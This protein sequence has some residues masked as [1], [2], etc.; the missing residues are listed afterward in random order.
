VAR[1]ETASW[2]QAEV[3]E[4]V[5]WGNLTRDE[6][7]PGSDLESMWRQDPQSHS[8]GPA[9]LAGPPEW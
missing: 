5:R 3:G 1:R 2:A 8:G 6:E 4:T 7:R 9:K